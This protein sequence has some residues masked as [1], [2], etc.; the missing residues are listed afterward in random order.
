MQALFKQ[1]H[2]GR[3]KTAASVE[4]ERPE[5]APQHEELRHDVARREAERLAF[6]GVVPDE[7]RE[8]AARAEALRRGVAQLLRQLGDEGRHVA[9]LAETAEPGEGRNRVV[10]KTLFD[11]GECKLPGF[12]SDFV[13][14][15]GKRF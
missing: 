6:A 5:H 15:V 8:G 14:E 1:E 7:R 10:A 3:L 13:G 12:G 4:D 11:H 2:V 9:E